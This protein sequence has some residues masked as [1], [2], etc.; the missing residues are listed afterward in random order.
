MSK[1]TT[2]SSLFGQTIDITHKP[3]RVQGENFKGTPLHLNPDKEVS[4]SSK[5]MDVPTFITLERA[6]T[7]YE[8]NSNSV[9]DE[10]KLYSVTAKWL[11]ELLDFRANKAKSGLKTPITE[12][13]I[14]GELVASLIAKEAEKKEEEQS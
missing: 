5:S 12:N 14:G 7:F 8:D 4:V 13:M 6:I 11:R 10:G 2:T 3:K 9:T 1:I